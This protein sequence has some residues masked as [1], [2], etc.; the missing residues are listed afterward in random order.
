MATVINNSGEDR[1]GGSKVGWIIGA[2]LLVLLLLLLFGG[3]FGGGGNGGEDA[4]PAIEQNGP[5]PGGGEPAPGG[6]ETSPVP[7][8]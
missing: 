2:I 1:P 6:G 8:Q 3:L 5:I 4:A 7:A